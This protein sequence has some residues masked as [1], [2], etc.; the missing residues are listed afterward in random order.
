MKARAAG[1]EEEKTGRKEAQRSVPPPVL[2]YGAMSLEGLRLLDK[3]RDNTVAFL[4]KK[5]DEAEKKAAEEVHPETVGDDTD[6]KQN[7][8]T[9]A[10]L[11]E[12]GPKDGDLQ[13]PRD[14]PATEGNLALTEEPSV[15]KGLDSNKPR[16]TGPEVV[17]PVKEEQANDESSHSTKTP[18][19]EKEAS[20][21]IN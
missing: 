20:T 7:T 15:P 2:D 21:T 13:P 10:V 4:L 6:D 3:A 8:T 1:E 17:E 12:P 19:Q 9:N 11:K 5:I 16:S 18:E 14:Q